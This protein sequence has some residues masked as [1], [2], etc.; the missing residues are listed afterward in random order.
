MAILSHCLWHLLLAGRKWRAYWRPLPTEVVDACFSNWVKPTPGQLGTTEIILHN[1]ELLR[2]QTPP[3]KQACWGP[4]RNLFLPA[5][6]VSL[7]KNIPVLQILPYLWMFDNHDHRNPTAA[8]CNHYEMSQ[9]PS[10]QIKDRWSLWI[11]FFFPPLQPLWIHSSLPTQA[12]D[13]S[14]KTT[15]HEI[16]MTPSHFIFLLSKINSIVPAFSNKSLKK[17]RKHIKYPSSFNTSSLLS[18]F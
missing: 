7:I 6:L 10:S 4:G 17:K 14:D 13:I 2:H 8:Y 11:I 9:E 1:S 3:C 16:Q 5:V 15:Q 12:A 18:T